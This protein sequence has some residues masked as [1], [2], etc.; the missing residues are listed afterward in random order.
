[1]LNL[2][3]LHYPPR[4]SSKRR[5]A[6]IYGAVLKIFKWLMQYICWWYNAHCSFSM[7]SSYTVIIQVHGLDLKNL[8]ISVSKHLVWHIFCR[9]VFRDQQF[10]KFRIGDQ[11]K[12]PLKNGWGTQN[13]KILNTIHQGIWWGFFFGSSLIPG[14]YIKKQY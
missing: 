2:M 12:E 11:V 8:D 9:F 1:M 7:C 4:I 3:A 14:N 10:L 13:I 5:I 6:A